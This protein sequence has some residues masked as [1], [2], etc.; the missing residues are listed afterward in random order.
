MW[1]NLL[2]P[3]LASNSVQ[4]QQLEPASAKDENWAVLDIFQSL[5]WFPFIICTKRPAY[6]LVTCIENSPTAHL[7]QPCQVCRRCRRRRRRRL[8]RAASGA[9]LRSA[10][11]SSHLLLGTTVQHGNIDRAKNCTLKPPCNVSLAEQAPTHHRNQVPPTPRPSL[12]TI[13]LGITTCAPNFPCRYSLWTSIHDSAVS[14]VCN[15]LLSRLGAATRNLGML[16]IGMQ[17]APEG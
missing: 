8:S 12:G 4:L 6:H 7:S 16:G 3:R 1:G 13:P 10:S 17:L 15:P 14:L 9:V 2:G 5:P 11:A